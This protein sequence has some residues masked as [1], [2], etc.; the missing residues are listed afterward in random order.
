MKQALPLGCALALL[1]TACGGTPA[2]TPTPAPTAPAVPTPLPFA[3]EY[4]VVSNE[5]GTPHHETLTLEGTTENGI[6]TALRFDVLVN[7]GQ[8]DEYSKRELSRY[9]MNTAG[10]EVTNTAGQWSLP[11][12]D[13][14]GYTE[15]E[16]IGQFAAFASA[17]T[18]TEATVFADLTFTDQNGDPM[19]LARALLL[20]Q[21]LAD[22][23][24]LTLTAETPVTAL[25]ALLGLYTHDGFAGGSNRISV[26]GANGGR[27]YGE[28]LDAIASYA[29]AH[30]MTLAQLYDLLRT[31]NQPAQPIAERDTVSGATITFSGDLQRLVYLAL[32]GEENDK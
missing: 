30:R 12:L 31:E 1:L 32:H 20:F 21:A 24:D 17:E 4:T 16:G 5:G 27:S 28:Q 26:A 10:A 18:L 13:L 14:Y 2:D 19:P 25:L 9:P 3:A 15:Q 22:E 29:L 11:R 23:G 7:K 8:E 6:L